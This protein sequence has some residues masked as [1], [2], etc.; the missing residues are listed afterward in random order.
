MS[1]QEERSG[2]DDGEPPCDAGDGELPAPPLSDGDHPARQLMDLLGRAHALAILYY[3]VRRDQ[4]PWRFGELQDELDVS[5]N[6]LSNRLSELTEAGLLE[7]QS[8]DEIPPRVE[9]VATTKARELNPTF[10]ELYRWADRHWPDAEAGFETDEESGSD[11]RE[12][13]GRADAE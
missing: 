13:T 3:L 9:Y 1:G 2:A 6:T 10:R 8:Y 11:E 12:D 7:R 4:R 5:P